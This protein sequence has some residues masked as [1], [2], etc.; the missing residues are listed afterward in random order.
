MSWIKNN[1]REC[2]K[3]HQPIEKKVGCSHMKCICGCEF[4]YECKGLWDEQHVQMKGDC[5]KRKQ[6]SSKEKLSDRIAE[7]ED[8]ICLFMKEA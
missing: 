1:T 8:D 5:P 2:P 7:L 4:C 6:F 3:C